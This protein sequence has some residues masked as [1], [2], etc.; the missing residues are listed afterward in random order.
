[1]MRRMTTCEMWLRASLAGQLQAAPLLLE[2]K[3]NQSL[4]HRKCDDGE[5]PEVWVP[6]NVRITTTFGT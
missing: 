6:G 1:M 4:A 3:I 2:A 5:S